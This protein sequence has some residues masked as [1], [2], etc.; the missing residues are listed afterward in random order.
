M[1][2][3]I[4]GAVFASLGLAAATGGTARADR[5]HADRADQLFKKGKKLLAEKKYPEACTAFEDSD[6]ADPGI[7]AKLNVAKCYEEW[8][9]LATAWRWYSDAEQ[10]ART[11]KDDRAPRIH[12]VLTELDGSVPRLTI[13]APAGAR[14]TDVVVKLDGVDIDPRTLGRER[15][16]DPGPHQID[17][18]VGGETQT[19][20]VP[21]ERGGS[22]EITLEVPAP[23]KP[24]GEPA[25]EPTEGEQD[26]GRN[27][28]FIAYGVGGAG[29]VA[30]G[31]A[32]IVAL[33][34]RGDYHDA[35]D[36]HCAG[37]TDTCD[38]AG[39]SQ[40]HNARS[41]ANIATAVTIGGL[42]AVAGGVYLYLTAPRTP[43][44]EHVVYVAPSV[45][46][47]NGLVIGGAF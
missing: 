32:G 22:S 45:G 5:E 16:V 37:A 27:R 40:T 39:L 18:V 47:S 11:G 4:T 1:K 7:G 28:R 13:S 42:A 24:V 43:R 35:L 10:M 30:I 19:K 44:D 26:P 38:D 3:W 36:A 23:R 9:K 46:T 34:A 21:V 6:K 17:T 31:V 8:G 41:R 2:L 12:A 29:V 14:L 25:T 20:V 15:R 33:R